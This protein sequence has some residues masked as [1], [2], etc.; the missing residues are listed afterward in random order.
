MV[1]AKFNIEGDATDWLRIRVQEELFAHGLDGNVLV[2]DENTLVVIVEGDKAKI[3]RLYTDMQEFLPANTT[4]TELNFSLNKPTRSAR[5]HED[6]LYVGREDII[7]Y[8]KEIDRKT[9]KIDQKL[10]KIISLLEEADIKKP[11]EEEEEAEV[12]ITEETTSVFAAM[13]GD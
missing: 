12:G 11:Q 5:I 2:G 7:E 13:F 8:L 1:S 4:L 3:K 9:T 6:R 10:N